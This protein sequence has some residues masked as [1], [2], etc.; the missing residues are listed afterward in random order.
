METR[1]RQMET[2]C[3]QT[4]L[5]TAEREQALH[6]KRRAVQL[7]PDGTA[8]LAKLQLVVESSAQRVVHLAG[9]W[10]KH[11][12]ALLA[13]Y[14]H[15]QKLQACR[16]LE[17]PRRPAEIQELHR[18]VRAAAK[19]A[20]RKERIYKRLASKLETLPRDVSQPA[21]TQRVLEIVGNIRKQ[22]EE[23]TKILSDTK[24]LQK[25]IDSLSGK[26]D[27]TFAVTDELV[28]KDAKKDG[29]VRKAYKYLAALCENCSQLLQTIEDWVSSY[30]RSETWWS[31]SR[32]RWA[33][34]PLT[35]WR[36]DPRGLPGPSPGER[37]PPG[38][39]P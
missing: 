14:R 5:S 1:C 35:T 15:L 13:E 38:A 7:L 36:E 34:R 23:I 22:K 11:R 16:E 33:R 27:R 19:E 21:Y 37:W 32:L 4:E 9:Q 30:G 24:Q 3:R 6:L 29:A 26:L 10:E 18:R 12:A 31:R 20:C 28:F 17:S 8:N 2:R 39:G 25:E